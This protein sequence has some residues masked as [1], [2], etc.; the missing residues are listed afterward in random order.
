MVLSPRH[1]ALLLP[2]SWSRSS[3]QQYPAEI[4]PLVVRP[5]YP[6]PNPGPVAEARGARTGGRRQLGL[7][8]EYDC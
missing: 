8:G 4:P 3:P 1:P 7:C 6:D 5:S 2:R